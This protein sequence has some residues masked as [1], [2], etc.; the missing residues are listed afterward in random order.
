MS[1]VTGLD[2][3]GS[4]FNAQA[5]FHVSADGSNVDIQTPANQPRGV[6]GDENYLY[7]V[8]TALS[9]SGM[10]IYRRPL[11]GGAR[12]QI[13]DGQAASPPITSARA[14]RP[15]KKVTSTFSASRITW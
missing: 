4:G 6:T 8:D 9:G 1:S 7:Y 10:G 5:I 15:S 13:L 12:E 2:G 14:V 11:E 3:I